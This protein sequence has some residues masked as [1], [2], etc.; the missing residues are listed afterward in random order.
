MRTLRS[1]LLLGKKRLQAG[2]GKPEGRGGARISGSLLSGGLLYGVYCFGP[3]VL[4]L[5]LHSSSLNLWGSI[6]W[7]ST[8]SGNRFCFE[9][10]IALIKLNLWGS[11]AT[12][13]GSAIALIKLESLGVYSLVVYCFGQLILDLQLHSS[14]SNLWGSTRWG[15]TLW[16]STVSGNRFLALTVIATQ[17]PSLHSSYLDM[18]SEHHGI[19]CS[20]VPFRHVL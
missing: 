13:F 12:D 2:W 19:V 8:V 16:E 15:S 9:S 17:A 14:S 6:L 20:A 1:K 4:D 18:C 3:S 10:G 5:E 11:R 7:W